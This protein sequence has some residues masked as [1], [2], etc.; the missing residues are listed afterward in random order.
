ME[1]EQIKVHLFT[2]VTSQIINDTRSVTIT[3]HIS[4]IKCVCMDVHMCAYFLN[5]EPGENNQEAR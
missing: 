4:F 5:E 2:V 1:H 3:S